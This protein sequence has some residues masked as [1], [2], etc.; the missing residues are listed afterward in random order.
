MQPLTT[1][2]TIIIVTILTS[3]STMANRRDRFRKGDDRITIFADAN[4]AG[5][6]AEIIIRRECTTVPTNLNDQISSISFNSTSSLL[7]C[8]F[9]FT[10][11]NCEGTRFLFTDATTCLNNLAAPACN[12]DNTIS[13][14]KACEVKDFVIRRRP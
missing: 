2:V 14:F 10:E 5:S 12:S 7:N 1:I 13:S 11:F 4:F 9:G 6:Q 8:V 3:K